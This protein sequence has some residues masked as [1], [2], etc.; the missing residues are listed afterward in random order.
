MKTKKEI[1]KYSRGLAKSYFYSFNNIPWEP[2]ENYDKDWLKDQVNDLARSVEI[3]M[4]W[5]QNQEETK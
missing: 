3:A 1:K 5:A 2:F 4:L